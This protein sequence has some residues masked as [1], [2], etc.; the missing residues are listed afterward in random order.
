[1]DYNITMLQ[2]S[3][4]MC[5]REIAKYVR[6]IPADN[7]VV[8]YM[9]SLADRSAVFP[10]Q[11]DAAYDSRQL[12]SFGIAIDVPSATALAPE[13]RHQVTGE[14]VLPMWHWCCYYCSF[15]RCQRCFCSARKAVSPDLLGQLLVGQ[16]ISERTCSRQE[17]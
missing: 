4:N 7:R 9:Y 13:A 8:W 2:Y 3:C 17:A 15:W 14:C 6:R 10:S 11:T 12:P 1:M 16:W 5:N